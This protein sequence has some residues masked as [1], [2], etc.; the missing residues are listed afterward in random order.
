MEHGIICRKPDSLFSYFG[1]G[2]VARM[3]E[4]TLVAVCSG[5]RTA[6]VCPWGKTELFYSYDDGKTWSEPVVVNDTVLDDRDAG[7]VHLGG[8]RLL[9]T[10]FNHPLRYC[11]PKETD[12][13]FARM[14]TA[15]MDTVEPMD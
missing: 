1:W 2:S 10:W 13:P 12:T 15:Y 7:I 9:M 4:H 3:D 11:E 14:M 6:H 8:K 5:Q